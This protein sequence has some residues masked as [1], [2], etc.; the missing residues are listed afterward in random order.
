MAEI[1]LSGKGSILCWERFLHPGRI[2]SFYKLQPCG[3]KQYRRMPILNSAGQISVMLRVRHQHDI[4]A[5][6]YIFISFHTPRAAARPFPLQLHRPVPATVSLTSTKTIKV[7]LLQEPPSIPAPK[8]V[9]QD[10]PR[11]TGHDR[12]VSGCMKHVVWA[13]LKTT[14]AREFPAARCARHFAA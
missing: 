1:A 2:N 7:C 11:R 3:T 14:K 10:E 4:A 9:R 6:S 5:K 8:T 12:F 13:K